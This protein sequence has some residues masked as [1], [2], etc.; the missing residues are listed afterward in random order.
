VE[1][2]ETK[3]S[4]EKSRIKLE[5]CR[6]KEKGFEIDSSGSRALLCLYGKI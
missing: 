5:Y 2:S 1:E 4:L 3:M 6:N